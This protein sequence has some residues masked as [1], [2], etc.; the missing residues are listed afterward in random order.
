MSFTAE[1]LARARRMV[2]PDRFARVI[3]GD[4]WIRA[5]HLE[6]L[7]RVL[8]KLV[9]RDGITRLM[10]N[11]PP[12]HGK[13]E[14]INHFLPAWF[15]ELFPA[16]RVISASHTEALAKYYSR[17]TR[18]T[19]L[20]NTDKLAVRLNPD[21]LAAAEWETTAGGG[22]I[23]RG[24]SGAT[25][26]KGGDLIIIDDPTKSRKE[27]LSKAHRAEVQSW[28]RSVIRTRLEPGGVMVIV[29]TRW[30]RD[31]LCGYLLRQQEEGGEDAEP[32]FVL[33]LPALCEELET[34]PRWTRHAGDALWPE[35]YSAETLRLIRSDVGPIE[36][37]AQFQGNPRSEGTGQFKRSRFRYFS[38][39]LEESG[40]RVFVLRDHDGG[41]K[42]VLEAECWWF[43]T[44][45]TAQEAGSSNDFTVVSTWIVTPD[46]ELLLFDVMRERIEIPLQL[47]FLY[48]QRERYPRLRFQGVEKASSGHSL[49]QQARKDGRP[50]KVL[51]ADADKVTRAGPISTLYANG[52]VYHRAG[53]PWLTAYEDE[54]LDFPGGDFDDQVDTASYAGLVIP[55]KFEGLR[56][57]GVSPSK[58]LGV[59]VEREKPKAR[60]PRRLDDQL[61]ALLGKG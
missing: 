16:K 4:A 21:V 7:G 26:G 37:A 8:A 10:V 51:K 29:Q 49:I 56:V 3:W 33:N 44:A 40:E 11:M 22:M 57:L 58:I 2:N 48:A 9:F 36:W 1:Q 32:W 50:F 13:S 15:L 38:E 24:V 30:A 27:A 19:L 14:L 5:K 6:L 12:R 39:Q 20:G 46:R 54:L 55:R 28:F 47:R 45:D 60:K 18:D 53:A 34:L 25:V 61:A 23:A 35:R 43:Q 17:R 31:D 42:R 52:V 59:T 41:E